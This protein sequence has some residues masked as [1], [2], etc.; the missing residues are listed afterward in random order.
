MTHVVRMMLLGALSLAIVLAAPAPTARAEYPK[1]SIYPIAWEL[2][3]KHGVPQRIVV[4]VPGTPAAQAYW[5]L[6]YRVTNTT[7]Q[8]R[9]FLPRFEMLTEDGRITRSDNTIHPRVFDAIKQREG[10]RFLEG[11]FNISTELRLGEDE[12]RDGVAIW[13]E[14]MPEMGR[15]SIFVE[16]LSGEIATVQAGEQPLT[17][18][19]TLRL[20]Y[21]IRGDEV[22][23]GED[24][25]NV[26]N[27]EWVMR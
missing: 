15:F 20:N 25:V 18:R 19:K 10:N 22:Y 9:V 11:I 14:P 7:D 2:A 27:F 24:E 26:D 8:E 6:T 13:V 1:P 12:A 23:P 5:Y 21:L 17:L 4:D 16:G 3:F